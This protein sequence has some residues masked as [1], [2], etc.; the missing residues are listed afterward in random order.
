[1]QGDTG[2]LLGSCSG[3]QEALAGHLFARCAIFG[4]RPYERR[5]IHFSNQSPQTR[6]RGDTR[7]YGGNI[8]FGIV[9]PVSSV[10]NVI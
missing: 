3:L 4:P 1:M 8:Y 6:R 7:A 5:S 9:V 10:D 2:L